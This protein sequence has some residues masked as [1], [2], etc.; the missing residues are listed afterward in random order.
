MGDRQADAAAVS[1]TPLPVRL[2]PGVDLRKALQAILARHGCE[3]AF[4]VAGIGSL[5]TASPTPLPAVASWWSLRRQEREQQ[6]IDF[7]RLLLLH[8]V[9]SVGDQVDTAHPRAGLAL[10]AR[11]IP[12]ALVDA[13]VALARDEA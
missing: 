2:E 5:E 6:A 12:G 1:C 11:E 7:V 10:H 9:P 3:A 8:P 13:P 4:V